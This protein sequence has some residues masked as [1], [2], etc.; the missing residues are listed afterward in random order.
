MEWITATSSARGF[1]QTVVTCVLFWE[2][3]GYCISFKRHFSQFKT[4]FYG[5]KRNEVMYY[6]DIIIS[7]YQTFQNHLKIPNSPML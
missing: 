7:R 6:V 2:M 4:Y 5:I 3:N 1:A